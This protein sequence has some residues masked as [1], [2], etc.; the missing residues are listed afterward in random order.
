MEAAA[1]AH[2]G[3]RGALREPKA[4]ALPLGEG[5]DREVRHAFQ[6]RREVALEVGVGEEQAP[7]RRLSLGER[8]GLSL[9]QA[10]QPDDAGACP[11]SGRG[12][13]IAGAVVRHDDLGVG[14]GGAEPLDGLLDPSLLVPRRDEDREWLSQPA[15]A[16]EGRR[17]PSA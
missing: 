6:Q 3:T 7:R 13:R 2:E 5:G 10:W 1:H 9:A 11:T 14:K 12:R 17:R 8:E 15:A 16:T 4:S